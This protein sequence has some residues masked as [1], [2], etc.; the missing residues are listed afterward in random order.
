MF[1]VVV[2]SFVS[3]ANRNN[4]NDSVVADLNPLMP[5]I[6]SSSV[7]YT[8]WCCLDAVAVFGVVVDNGVFWYC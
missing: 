3:D 8:F 7:L 5:S 1:V 4:D 2:D 6:L